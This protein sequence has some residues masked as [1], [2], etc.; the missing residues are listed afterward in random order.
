[1]TCA[2]LRDG[3]GRDRCG[4][5]GVPSRRP[6]ARPE[7]R[8]AWLLGIATNVT[9]NTERAARRHQAALRTVPPP[10]PVPDVADAVTQRLAGTEELAAA[11]EALSKML[12]QG[13]GSSVSETFTWPPS[14]YG[15]ACHPGAAIGR[16]STY[17]TGQ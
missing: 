2:A 5:V 7:Q 14:P 8:R 13:R 15:G 17:G 12:H 16:I 1:M 4:P 9:C 11:P 3:S 6:G 10:G